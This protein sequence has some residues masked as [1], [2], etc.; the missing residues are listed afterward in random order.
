MPQCD[1]NECVRMPKDVEFRRVS[2][3]PCFR[4]WRIVLYVL[5]GRRSIKREILHGGNGRHRLADVGE[6]LIVARLDREM[7]EETVHTLAYEHTTSIASSQL[8]KNFAFD[9]V[10]PQK[11]PGVEALFFDWRNS[12]PQRKTVHARNRQYCL[13]VLI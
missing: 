6:Q 5:D 9:L 11:W 8:W 2:H 4:L 3:P 13:A 1:C 10:A 12:T 7:F